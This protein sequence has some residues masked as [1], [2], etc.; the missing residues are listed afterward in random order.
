[1]FDGYKEFDLAIGHGLFAPTRCLNDELLFVVSKVGLNLLV[2]AP[3]WSL[4]H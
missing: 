3:S 4:C 2:D 1:V